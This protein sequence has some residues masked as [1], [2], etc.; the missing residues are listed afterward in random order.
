VVPDLALVYRITSATLT[1]DVDPNAL[2]IRIAYLLLLVYSRSV[3][4][5]V[6]AFADSS[7]SAKLSITDRLARVFPIIAAILSNIAP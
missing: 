2:S 4:I 3:K 5:H 1:R 7:P 6:L